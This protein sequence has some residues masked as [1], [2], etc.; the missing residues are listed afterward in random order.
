MM[1]KIIRKKCK[2]CGEEFFTTKDNK[3]YITG[4]QKANNNN[5]QNARRKRLHKLN[6]PLTKAYEVFDQLL[7]SKISVEVTK[8]FLKGRNIKPGWMT[9]LD[10]YKGEMAIFLHDII[11]FDNPD[12][13]TLKRS[14]HA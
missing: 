10:I 7:G 13:L 2:C 9:N 8:E 11:I 5:I 6:S 4:H 14:K 3:L 12:H 1:K